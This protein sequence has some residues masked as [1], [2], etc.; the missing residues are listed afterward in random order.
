[1]TGPQDLLSGKVEDANG[2]CVKQVVLRS[3]ALG[4]PVQGSLGKGLQEGGRHSGKAGEH[5]GP[6][7]ILAG[8]GVQLSQGWQP[9]GTAG[10]GGEFTA[11][12]VT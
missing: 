3:G 4:L 10:P 9:R 8:L 1:M 2:P 12:L 5:L 11:G 7:K 6:R